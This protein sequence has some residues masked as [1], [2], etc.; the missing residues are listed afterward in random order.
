[1][2]KAEKLSNHTKFN[3]ITQVEYLLAT[4]R[5]MQYVMHKESLIFITFVNILFMLKL[6]MHYAIKH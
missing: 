4:I 6:S 3:D 1:M 2:Q 5:W